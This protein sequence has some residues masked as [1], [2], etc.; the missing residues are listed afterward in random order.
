[1]SDEVRDPDGRPSGS[2]RAR[3][4]AGRDADDFAAWFDDHFDDGAA[5]GADAELRSELTGGRQPE[6]S[7][8][9]ALP[10]SDDARNLRDGEHD[11]GDDGD[12]RVDGDDE[13][14]LASDQSDAS[15]I[16]PDRPLVRRVADRVVRRPLAWCN[17]PWSTER[18]LRLI[19]TASSLVV[20]TLIVSRVV[21][22]TPLPFAGDSDLILDQTTPTGGDMGAHVWAPAFLRDHLIANGQ[23]S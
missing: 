2:D 7:G 8:R 4:D 1:M 12:Q 6:S 5:D 3:S 11:R 9:V 16:P 10:A 21:H 14:V 19:V 17:A 15:S 13:D 18:I 22:F 23:L 20:T